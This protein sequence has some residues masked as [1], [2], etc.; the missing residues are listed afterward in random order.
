MENGLEYNSSILVYYS[1]G[2]NQIEK[3]IQEFVKYA[4]QGQRG[5]DDCD[6]RVGNGEKGG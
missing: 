6:V 3:R 5:S 1:M 2:S 4:D